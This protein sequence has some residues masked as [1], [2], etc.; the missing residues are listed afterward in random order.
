M[1]ALTKQD[2]EV[3]YDHLKACLRLPIDDNTKVERMQSLMMAFEKKKYLNQ[4]SKKARKHGVI[5]R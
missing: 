1:K 2:Y 3:L 4:T 5:Q